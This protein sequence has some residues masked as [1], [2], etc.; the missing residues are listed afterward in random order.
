MKVTMKCTRHT[1]TVNL[2]DH[3][4]HVFVGT[5]KNWIRR[6]PTLTALTLVSLSDVRTRVALTRMDPFVVDI[7][8]CYPLVDG[9][10][11]SPTRLVVVHVEKWTINSTV[12][13]FVCP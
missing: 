8:F 11:F 3:T 4:P 5:L 7:V 13:L 12:T 2:C 9:T 1:L 6:G 10:H